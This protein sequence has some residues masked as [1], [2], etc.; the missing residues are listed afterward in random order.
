MLGFADEVSA[1]L[2]GIKVIDPLPN[3]IIVA[4]EAIQS[5]QK[6]DKADLPLPGPKTHLG[7]DGMGALDALMRRQRDD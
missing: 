6:T 2:D 5:G 7:F 3:A 1:A 4:H